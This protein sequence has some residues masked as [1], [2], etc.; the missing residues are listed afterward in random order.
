MFAVLVTLATI[1]ITDHSMPCHR[2][3]QTPG[4]VTCAHHL[5]KM[6]QG[7]GGTHGSCDGPASDRAHRSLYNSS[8]CDG[9]LIALISFITRV[10]YFTHLKTLL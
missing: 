2:V 6:A 7:V 4:H 3:S 5:F 1:K 10:F 8:V 9:V